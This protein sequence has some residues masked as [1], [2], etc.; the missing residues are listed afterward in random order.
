M[1]VLS[2]IWLASPVLFFLILSLFIYFFMLEKEL[3]TP[4]NILLFGECHLSG[5]GLNI[6]DFRGLQV[7]FISAHVK[8]MVC[9]CFP[10]N[11]TKRSIVCTLTS[12]TKCPQRS[13]FFWCCGRRQPRQFSSR[14]LESRAYGW[15]WGN[16]ARQR[17]LWSPRSCHLGREKVIIFSSA[18]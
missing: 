14:V 17:I 2:A 3:W 13:K 15:V 8:V 4:G 1:F 11:K 9:G 5:V 12:S 6:N 16:L 7:S 18:T 10:Q